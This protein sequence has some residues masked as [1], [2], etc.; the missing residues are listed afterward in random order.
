MP[1]PCF[2]D[3]LVHLSPGGRELEK[4]QFLQAFQSSEFV[5]PYSN[6]ASYPS[7]FINGQSMSNAASKNSGV[8]DI[9]HVNSVKV[10]NP[11]S[12]PEFPAVQGRTSSRFFPKFERDRGF[13]TCKTD[14]WLVRGHGSNTMATFTENGH[15]LV[16]DNLGSQG[17]ARVLEFDPKTLGYPWSYTG[18]DSTAFLAKRRGTK[19]RLPNG[20]TLIVDPEGGRILEVTRNRECVWEFSCAIDPELPVS[21][22]RGKPGHHGAPVATV[23]TYLIF[24]RTETKVR[25]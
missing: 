23:R 17:N 11:C 13:S 9:L 12:G 3:Y 7:D 5:H 25:P 4:I 6:K 2:V 14:P 15:L 10:L 18:Q 24:S 20:N 16:Y 21:G 19:Q 1:T 22:R 8:S